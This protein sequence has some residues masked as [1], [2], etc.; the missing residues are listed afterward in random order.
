LNVIDGK[1]TCKCV[2]SALGFDYVDPK[3]ALS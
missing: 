1:V 3:V 2:A